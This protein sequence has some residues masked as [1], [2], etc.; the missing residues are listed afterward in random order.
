MMPRAT[1]FW[2]MLLAIGLGGCV[3]DGK[4]GPDGADGAPGA[5][6]ATGPVG[7]G[8]TPGT[9]ATD[10]EPGVDAEVDVD[11]DGLHWTVD[12]D[13]GDATVGEPSVYY[14][15]RDGDG[16]GIARVENHL[17]EPMVGWVT[18][19]GDCDDLDPTVRP[20]GDEICDGQDNN[21]DGLADDD[22]PGV[23]LST[24][25]L[26][27]EDFDLDG[28]GDAAGA[29]V[30]ACEE[31]PG[32]TLQTGDCDETDPAVSPAADEICNNGVDD[33]CNGTRDTC[34]IED[35]AT[36][37]ISWTGPSGA[38]FGAD[39]ARAGDLDGDGDDELIVGARYDSSG[40]TYSGAAYVVYGGTSLAG[41]SPSDLRWPGDGLLDYAGASVA[42]L[43]DVDNDGYDDV[44]IG[45]ANDN[46]VFVVFGGTSLGSGDLGTVADVAL[47]VDNGDDFGVAV[48]APGDIDGD[49]HADFAIAEEDCGPAN[50][51]SGCVYLFAGET[52]LP[53]SMDEDDAA[54]VFQGEY[55]DFDAFGATPGSVAAADWNG[56]G[57]ADLAVGAPGHESTASNQGLVVV[58][59]GPLSDYAGQETSMDDAAWLQV[60]GEGSGDA[61]GSR[62]AAVGDLD[63]DGYDELAVTAP[64]SDEE[65]DAGGAAYVFY[66]AASGW[67]GRSTAEDADL[68]IY[69][70]VDLTGVGTDVAG[71]DLDLDGHHDLAVG[72]L[73]TSYAGSVLV[74][75]GGSSRLTGTRVPTDADLVLAGT[76]AYDR[77]GGRLTTADRNGDGVFDLTASATGAGTVHTWLGGAL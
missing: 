72:S 43:G 53:A 38:D 69:G 10:G 62:V 63:G 23:D 58:I 34:G 35:G 32:R 65:A 44:L 36:P 24:G 19:T 25:T 46:G 27:F 3:E 74:F 12:C 45:S 30:L 31:A 71:A 54:M 57:L 6:G 55:G 52:S 21:C 22:D 14:M 26:F 13:D 77:L 5:D 48:H 49:G 20:D 28:F 37:D 15:D 70:D 51:A 9:D 56:D 2:S 17:C 40:G 66:G 39:L 67:S 16:Y 75:E 8:G 68:R 42:G 1:S 73:G 64:E 47:R 18:T 60:L 33:N 41:G 11:G 4:A 59:D 7:D 50:D 29:T 76:T 61:L